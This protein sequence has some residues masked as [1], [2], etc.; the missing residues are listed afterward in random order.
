MA[1]TVARGPRRPHRRAARRPADRGAS[2]WCS[3]MGVRPRGELAEAAGLTI[4]RGAILIDAQMRARC[5]RARR[6]RR[7]LRL[8]RAPAGGCASSTGATRS[9][10]ARSPD[11]S[12]PARTPHWDDVP[13]FW[14]TIGEHTLKYA[15]WG[16]GYDEPA[17]SMSTPRARS[18]SG[19]P[20]TASS[21]ACSPTTVTRTTSRGRRADRRGR[22]PAEHPCSELPRR[23]RLP[24]SGTGAARRV[25]AI[26][27]IPARDEAAR[28]G[29]CLTALATQRDVTGDSYEVIVFSTVAATAPSS[30]IRRAA[31]APAPA[32]PRS[33]LLPRRRAR[34]APGDGHRLRAAPALG[35]SDGLIASTDA[36]TVVAADWLAV[37]SRSRARAPRRSAGSSSSIPRTR[38]ARLPPSACASRAPPT[39]RQLSENAAEDGV[40]RAPSLLGRVARRDRRRLRTLRRAAAA[41]G[42]RGRGARRKRSPGKASRSTA[43]RGGERCERRPAPTGVP[44]AGSRR[45]WRAPTG[46]ARRNHRAKRVSPRAAARGRSTTRSR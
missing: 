14:S 33:T 42:T 29:R 4:A 27:V 5:A 25:Q 7:R 16:D 44:L 2:T 12:S 41:R 24:T 15:A 32:I 1:S 43:A 34:P 10:R 3:R 30:V 18:P 46:V 40:G 8:N 21:S 31:P 17:A 9:A 36:D 20:A 26:V 35:A 13:G 22:E 39:A 11:A 6:R 23:R 28:I 19:I 45:T 37:S 38:R